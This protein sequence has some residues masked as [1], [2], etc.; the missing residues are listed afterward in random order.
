MTIKAIETRYA[1]CRFRSRLEARWAVFFDHL[2]I[3][4]E[5]EPQ[6][7]ELPRGQYLPD[8]YLPGIGK[9]VE[10]K[11]TVGAISHHNWEVMQDF[12]NEVAMPDDKFSILFS[13]PEPRKK[14]APF[15]WTVGWTGP[16]PLHVV[17]SEDFRYGTIV[18]TG[19]G[20]DDGAIYPVDETLIDGCG[21]IYIGFL[22]LLWL[23]G[24][25]DQVTQ[26]LIAARSARFEHGEAG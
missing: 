25:Q 19:T 7:F 10:I 6:G 16:I 24:T 14:P 2:D 17:T 15:I 26:A 18:T 20:P 12:G 5:Y 3:R 4:W 1:G 9:W 21:H 13:L 23:A 8:F 22:P 11:A